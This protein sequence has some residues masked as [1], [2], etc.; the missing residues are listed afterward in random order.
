MLKH[1]NMCRLGIDMYKINETNRVKNKDLIQKMCA[2]FEVS[3][4]LK[5]LQKE[6][7]KI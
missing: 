5:T 4:E 7:T 6:Q 2:G 1:K 3:P